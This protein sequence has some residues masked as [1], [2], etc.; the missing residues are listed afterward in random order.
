[1]LQ[2]CWCQ[3]LCSRSQLM[4]K[5]RCFCNS[6]PNECYALSCPERVRFQGIIS[7][8]N[9]PVQVK[10]RQISVG[11]SLRAR[12]LDSAQ[13]SLLRE[14]GAQPNWSSRSSGHHRGETQTGPRQTA[15]ANQVAAAM[16]G[17]RFTASS[18]P[19]SRLAS[20]LGE[21]SDTLQN[22]ACP[23]A[24]RAQDCFSWRAFGRTPG[25]APHL[26]P[27]SFGENARLRLSP[28]CPPPW[29][30]CQAPPLPTRPASLGRPPGSASPLPARL[31]GET[32]RLRPSPHCPPPWGECQALPLPS[33]PSWRHPL[34]RRVVPSLSFPNRRLL[35]GGALHCAVSG[36][37]RPAA[38]E[39]AEDNDHCDGCLAEGC[40][41]CRLL[42]CGSRAFTQATH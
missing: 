1:M 25:S 42:Q 28:H 35:V 18:R 34:H 26:T 23:L 40:T 37:A 16:T 4:V 38:W 22:T 6:L 32:A 5:K 13:L 39:Q 14:P 36:R 24:Q 29:G 12:S 2:T 20:G 10:R 27:A 11:S 33:L 17:E 21:A 30:E 8:S 15:T 3:I 9:V 19:G 41:P 7:P 31:P